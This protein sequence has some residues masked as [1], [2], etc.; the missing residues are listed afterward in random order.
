M[1]KQVEDWT[2]LLNRAQD[3]DIESYGG[4]VER[5]QDMAVGYGYAILRDMFLAQDAAQDVYNRLS[6]LH[7]PEAF[8]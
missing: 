5:F 6:T 3:G 4:I 2:S 8:L 1:E 7:A